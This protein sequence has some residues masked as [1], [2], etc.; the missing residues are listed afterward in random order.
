MRE[1]RT[2]IRTRS[3]LN[4][5]HMHTQTCHLNWGACCLQV[6]WTEDLHAHFME[7]VERLGPEQAMPSKILESLGASGVG[8]TCQSVSAHLL[9]YRRM[10]CHSHAAS[11][12]PGVGGLPGIPVFPPGGF[13]MLPGCFPGAPGTGMPGAP[14]G[15]FVSPLGLPMGTNFPL[16]PF[17]PPCWMP[18][19]YGTLPG[20]YD[21]RDS[22]RHGMP[23]KQHAHP[24][25]GI[26]AT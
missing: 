25:H 22:C 1:Q 2:C 24:A 16:M 15:N 3:C 10:Q 19:A 12:P 20:V 5:T 21:R 9:E 23:G 6:E 26:I 18:P 8:L 7:V 13:P 4:F 14:P 11:L 17:G